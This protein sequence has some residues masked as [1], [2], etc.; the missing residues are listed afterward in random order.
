MFDLRAPGFGIVLLVVVIGGSAPFLAY[1]GYRFVLG[2]F[3]LK[4]LVE[5]TERLIFGPRF[6]F[7]GGVSL[8]GRYV[9]KWKVFRTI[10]KYEI[11]HRFGMIWLF[12]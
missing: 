4:G 12:N 5:Y 10:K 7:K 9:L 11:V 8:V 2:G 3:T 1:L 6:R